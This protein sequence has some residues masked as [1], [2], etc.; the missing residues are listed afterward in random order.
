MLGETAQPVTV[1]QGCKYL[2]TSVGWEYCTVAVPPCSGDLSM[3]R[4]CSLHADISRGGV[5]GGESSSRVP[6]SG[7]VDHFTIGLESLLLPTHGNEAAE[8][9]TPNKFGGCV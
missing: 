4:G 2:P 3:G 9:P 8:K 7:D 6:C 5:V 1:G